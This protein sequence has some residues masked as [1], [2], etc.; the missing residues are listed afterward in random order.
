MKAGAN[1][2]IKGPWAEFERRHK[3]DTERVGSLLSKVTKLLVKPMLLS[4][5]TTR[6]VSVV[7]VEL[8]NLSKT[9]T[10]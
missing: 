4:M 9:W 3:E 5:F 8:R 7:T 6:S 10:R 1:L 2:Y